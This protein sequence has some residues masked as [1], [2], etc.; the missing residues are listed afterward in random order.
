M[1][2]ESRSFWSQMSSFLGKSLTLWAS[3]NSSVTQLLDQIRNPELGGLQRPGRQ[4]EGGGDAWGGGLWP[5]KAPVPCPKGQV[6]LSSNQLLPCETSSFI[7]Y[8]FMKE[9]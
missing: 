7:F 8:L 5:V 4:C 6:E 1:L 9:K 2:G 3:S